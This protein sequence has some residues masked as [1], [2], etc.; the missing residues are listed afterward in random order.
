MSQAKISLDLVN[1]AADRLVFI[2]KSDPGEA[3]AR[4]TLE[5]MGLQFSIR[6]NCAKISL[7]GA[8]M[9]GA[10]GVAYRAHRCLHEAQVPVY[11]STD[12]NITISCLI[13]ACDLSK[14][15]AAVHREFEMTD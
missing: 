7:V 1:F 11:H 3:V 9:R 15:V 12:S 13:P 2:V 14:A 4:K 5:A 8:G 6:S 10:P